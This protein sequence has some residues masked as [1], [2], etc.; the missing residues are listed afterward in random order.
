MTDNPL[1]SHFEIP[2][3][4]Q[5]DNAH[6]MPAFETTME[7]HRLEIK[8]IKN[9]PAP[10]DF[11][12]TVEA[13]ERSG[14]QLSEVSSI[15]FNLRS[16]ESNDEIQQIARKVSP[17]LTEHSNSI[18]TDAELFGKVKAVYEQKDHLD[19]S[20]EQNTLLEEQYR[21]FVRNGALLDDGKKEKLKEIDQK[22]S[23]LGLAYGDN[24]LADSND[25]KL[26]VNKEEDLAGLPEN[27][28]EA[29]QMVAKEKG[30][31]GKWVFTLDFPSYGPFM[32]YADNRSL[33]EELFC[34]MG[35]RSARGNKWDNREN[36]KSIARLRRK[37]ANLLGYPTHAHFVL[38]KRMAETPEKVDSFLHELMDKALPAARREL[39]ELKDFAR[40]NGFEGELQRWDVAYWGEKLKKSRFDLDDETLRP[41]FKLENVVE[42]IFKTANKLYGI[43]FQE[44]TNVPVY[45]PE[46][47]VFEVTGSDEKTIGLFYT[48]LFPRS[49]KR[50]GAWATTFRDQYKSGDQNHPPRVSIVCNFTRPTASRPSL[51]NF[52]EVT[53]LFHEFGHA[54]HMLLSDCHYKD[55]SGASVY[56]D[57]VE[58]PSQVME[59][60]PKEQECLE[61]FATHFESGET[62]P[63]DMVK[64]LADSASFQ[65][66]T[67]TIRQVGLGLLDMA[68]H[69]KEAEPEKVEDVC[70]YEEN[71]LAPIQLLPTVEGVMTSPSFGHIFAGGY[72]AGYYSYK[73]AEVL[74]ADAFEL[75]K[76]K[77]IFDRE[78]ANRFRAEILQRGGSEHPMNLYKRFRGRE[79]DTHALLKRAGLVSAQ[80]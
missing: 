4:D 40:E 66:G 24:V 16:A 54:L 49:G 36:L 58:L 38:E 52:R 55:L 68:W 78:T 51:L 74:D 25:Y 70:Q 60:W 42:G 57:F 35:K 56:W 29:A 19:L 31:E 33:R 26:V 17:L 47:R 28:K 62:I 50:N 3:F 71:L 46:V 61:L 18:N 41:Y 79:P 22:L 5:I 8:M 39:E 67:A 77:G 80:T 10:P 6:F 9:N 30:E 63:S 12:N 69:W 45:H 21:S 64:K 20:P 37:R 23:E 75:F 72:S 43:R 32:T 27:V 13:L 34:A 44:R 73:W 59:N 53:T 15:F 2:P 65:E 1:L 14:Q 11:S 7:S 76:E 48:D